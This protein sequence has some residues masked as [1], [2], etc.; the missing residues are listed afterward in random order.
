MEEQ[1]DTYVD[2]YVDVDVGA[3]AG[4]GVYLLSC[5]E[6]VTIWMKAIYLVSVKIFCS[7]LL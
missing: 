4:V 5:T 7:I 3:C 2:V 1:L 6:I